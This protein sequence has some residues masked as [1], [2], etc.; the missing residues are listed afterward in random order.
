VFVYDVRRDGK[1]FLINTKVRRAET[2]PMSVVLNW[3]AKVNK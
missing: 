3:D 2:A 1:E